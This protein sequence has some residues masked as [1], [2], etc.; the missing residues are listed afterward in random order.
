MRFKQSYCDLSDYMN[1]P[2]AHSLKEVEYQKWAD[3]ATYM[4]DKLTYG[5]AEKHKDALASELAYACGQIAEILS[6]AHSGKM[7]TAG[8]RAS[9]SN[10]GYSESYVA[11]KGVSA[12]VHRLCYDALEEA[13]G[14]DP[15]GLL[16]AG[17][18]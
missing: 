16:Y 2:F 18:I 14:A 6:S 15:Y 12:A 11:A 1:G 9:A 17:V 5:R 4:I 10:D 8:G 3:Q 7:A 13:L